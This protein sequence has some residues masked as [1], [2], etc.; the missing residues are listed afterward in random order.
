MIVSWYLSETPSRALDTSLHFFR[1]C[2][3]F[4]VG[5]KDG[6]FFVS[7]IKLP[8]ELSDLF[9]VEEQHG[10]EKSRTE[11]SARLDSSS[12]I[13]AVLSANR[14]PSSSVFSWV[15]APKGKSFA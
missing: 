9:G 15:F 4:F 5:P 13:L 3:F 8:E 6:Q 1:T 2:R 11:E 12:A 7:S 14:A 10:D